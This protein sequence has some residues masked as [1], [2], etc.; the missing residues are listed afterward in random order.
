MA[1]NILSI[2]QILENHITS[3]IKS[4]NLIFNK[5]IVFLDFLYFKFENIKKI[6]FIIFK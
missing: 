1:Q 6:T 4:L 2:N 5:L 3:I